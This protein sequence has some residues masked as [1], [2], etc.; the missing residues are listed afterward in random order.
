MNSER[1]GHSDK[2]NNSDRISN[3]NRSSISSSNRK[4]GRN[5]INANTKLILMLLI[6]FGLVVNHDNHGNGEDADRDAHTNEHAGTDAIMVIV[7]VLMIVI[8]LITIITIL[9][10]ML[11]P[12]A[13]TTQ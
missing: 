13:I 11:F 4:A 9:R 8:L 10:R 6:T 7:M 5:I 2:H 1:P 12:M 3:D